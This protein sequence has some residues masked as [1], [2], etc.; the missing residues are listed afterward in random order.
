MGDKPV[1]MAEILEEIALGDETGK[2]LDLDQL[3]PALRYLVR[4]DLEL[5]KSP[6]TYC[7]LCGFAILTNTVA[8]GGDL[9]VHGRC[10]DQR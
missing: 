3:Y 5:V 10:Y 2:A 6:R 4:R 1:T 8:L 9:Y 7:D